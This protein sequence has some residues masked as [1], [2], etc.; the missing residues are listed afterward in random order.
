MMAEQSS[1]DLALAVRSFLTGY[2]STCTRSGKTKSAYTIDLLQFETH[3]G[4]AMQL[5]QIDSEVLERWAE[6]LKCSE[7]AAGSIRRKFAALKVFFGYWVRKGQ[8]PASPM[9][10]IKLDLGREL[11]L[12]RSLPPEDAARLL[13]QAWIAV[14]ANAPKAACVVGEPAFLSLRNV[15]VIEILL[16]TGI[17][18]GELVSLSL[19]D[20][21]NDDS[22]FVVRS[23]GGRQRLA[24][25]TG[26][27]A[28]KVVARYIAMRRSLSLDHDSL[29]PNAKGSPLGTQGV[30]RV[31]T[32][33]ATASGVIGKLTPHM[34]RHTVATL[35]LKNGADIRVV[36]EVLGHSSIT[37][38]QRYTHVSKE[39]M[40]KALSTFLPFVSSTI[41]CINAASNP[42]S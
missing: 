3:V 18:V 2:F 41:D 36:Q 15:T 22:S 4:P 5:S 17:R 25:I 16:A 23:K 7:Y 14:E 8:I 29:F 35:M 1:M 30:A 26:E 27:R 10:R 20:W 34:T 32:R 33:L 39:H 38:T 28:V 31:L 12:P 6:H 21:R 40:R 42:K 37:M 24:I 11:Q 19:S 13:R 9:W